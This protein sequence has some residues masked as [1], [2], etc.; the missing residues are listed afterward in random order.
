MADYEYILKEKYRAALKA[1]A[2]DPVEPE[3]LDYLQLKNRDN[4]EAWRRRYDK[5]IR[6]SKMS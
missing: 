6:Q 4:H 5:A 2:S 1:R 3:I